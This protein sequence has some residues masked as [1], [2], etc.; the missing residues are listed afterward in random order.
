M[1]QWAELAHIHSTPRCFEHDP[2]R[3][4]F[5]KS[6]VPSQRDPLIDFQIRLCD[7][8]AHWLCFPQVCHFCG[9]GKWGREGSVW[10]AC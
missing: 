3:F 2:Y 10:P 4:V 7:V 8:S 9:L 5:Y 1:E 6:A